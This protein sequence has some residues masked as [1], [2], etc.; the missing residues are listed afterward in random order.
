M[1]RESTQKAYDARWV[2]FTKWCKNHRI[3]LP[4]T[5][6]VPTIARFMSHLRDNRKLSG[7]TI[8]NYVSGIATVRDIVTN[9]SLAKE[10]VLRGIIKGFKQQDLKRSKLRPPAWDLNIVLRSLTKAPYEPLGEA[11]LQ[12][13]TWKTVF[14]LSF[15]TAA[16]VSEVHALDISRIR[17]D[18]GD[19][20]AVR[21]GLLMGFVAKNQ[22]YGQAERDFKIKSLKEIVGP[23][24][25]EDRSLCPV[26]ALKHYIKASQKIRKG[27]QRLFISVNPKREVDIT[28]NSISMWIR[29]VI[30][31]AYRLAEVPVPGSNPHEI[32]ALAA[33][34]ALHSNISVNRIVKGCF[35]S[36]D[37]IFANHY[38]RDVSDEDVEGIHRLGPLIAAQAVLKL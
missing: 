13:V 27:R 16:R 1:H 2:I 29:A 25:V 34:F 37:S 10:P 36:S 35:W 14:L 32:R 30:N 20:G 12:H 19:V 24:D 22:K 7:G 9:T 17:F 26:R 3:S 18:R 8:A 33:T 31:L 6:S 28:R 38:L 4:G 15:A 11:S 21:L 23:N 5:A